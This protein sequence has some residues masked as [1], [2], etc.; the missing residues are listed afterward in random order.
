M[1][2]YQ[3][4]EVKHAYWMVT[5]ILK[6][7]NPFAKEQVIEA[8]S[9]RGVDCRPFFYPLSSLPAYAHMPQAHQARSRNR[10]SYQLSPFGINLPSGLNL[11]EEDVCL[12][13]QTLME[14]LE[15]VVPSLRLLE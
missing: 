11:K 4:P 5:V 6:E 14:I 10:I 3:T 7:K 13:S 9:E 12:V 1:L 15:T 8:M 2:N